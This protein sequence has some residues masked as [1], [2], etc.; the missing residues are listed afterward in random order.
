VHSDAEGRVA[1]YA[2]E[3]DDYARLAAAPEVA[4][5]KAMRSRRA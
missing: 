5:T 4:H 2:R 1:L 3:S